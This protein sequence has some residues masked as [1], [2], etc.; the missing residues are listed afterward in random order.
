[1]LPT[2]WMTRTVGRSLTSVWLRVRGGQHI[3]TRSTSI[4]ELKPVYAVVY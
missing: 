3:R 4:L 2:L 1:M